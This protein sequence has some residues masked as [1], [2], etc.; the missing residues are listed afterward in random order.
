MIISNNSTGDVEFKNYFDIKSTCNLMLLYLRIYKK[1]KKYFHFDEL[2]QL[3]LIKYNKQIN[4]F[5]I[6]K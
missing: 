3:L 6:H 1:D 5:E 4:K 2:T